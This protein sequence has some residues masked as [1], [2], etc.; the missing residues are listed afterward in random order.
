MYVAPI[1]GPPARSRGHACLDERHTRFVWFVRWLRRRLNRHLPERIDVRTVS[2]R[3]DN[4][5]RRDGVSN[6]DEHEESVAAVYAL[7]KLAALRPTPQCRFCVP[8][9]F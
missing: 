1:G 6:A 3:R 7:A 4:R 8:E 5:Q 2:S 9:C